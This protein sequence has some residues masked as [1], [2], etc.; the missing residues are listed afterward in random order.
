MGRFQYNEV[1]SDDKKGSGCNE[2]DEEKQANQKEVK[3][4]KDEAEDGGEG[5][6]KEET[7][8]GEQLQDDLI[9]SFCDK[10]Q[11]VC[12]HKLEALLAIQFLLITDK[13][14]VRKHVTGRNSAYQVLYDRT[15]SHYLL[16]HFNVHSGNVEIYDSLQ[17]YDSNWSPFINS[18]IYRLIVH[19]FGHLYRKAIPIVIDREYETQ[20]DNFS[21]GYRVI[22]ALVDLARGKNPATQKYSRHRLLDF[23]KKV[24]NEPRPTWNMFVNAKLGKAKSYSGEYK[25]AFCILNDSYV[26]ENKEAASTTTSSTQSTE[27]LASTS[28]STGSRVNKR[29]HMSQL[30]ESSESTLSLEKR[31]YRRAHAGYMPRTGI[32]PRELPQFRDPVN[33]PSYRTARIPFRHSEPSPSSPTF[34]VGT[35]AQEPQES[36]FGYF[37]SS[38]Q[39]LLGGFFRRPKIEEIE[40]EAKE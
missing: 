4:K 28:S 39:N 14:E 3:E 37:R 19:T 33:Y 7:Q 29:S 8:F 25:V 12:P 21:C 22:G 20:L 26:E 32:Y 35:S 1:S 10:L 34:H 36:F 31:P 2:E 5:K 24:L 38:C 17:T 27:S 30:S 11:A 16:V 15:R 13:A 18:E 6:P 9:N 40:Q 23:M